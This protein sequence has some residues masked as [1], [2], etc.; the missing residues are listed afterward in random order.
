MTQKITSAILCLFLLLTACSQ[1]EELPP[2]TSSNAETTT[3][4]FY[5]VKRSGEQ[6]DTKGVAQRTNLWYPGSVRTNKEP[7]HI[8]IISFD[9]YDLSNIISICTRK[10]WIVN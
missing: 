2:G 8:Y 7:G 6:V 1:Q 10:N 9:G 4:R 3:N 5:G